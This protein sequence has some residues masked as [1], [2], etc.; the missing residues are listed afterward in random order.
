M[1]ATVAHEHA[2][3]QP[4]DSNDQAPVAEISDPLAM[5]ALAHPLRLRILQLLQ[6]DGP[7][8]ATRLGAALDESSG[9]TS[10]HLRQLAKYG[11]IEELADH[12]SARER[13]WRARA[14]GFR[15]ASIDASNPE[16]ET[17][18]VLLRSRILDQNAEI[19][20]QFLDHE[21]E[22]DPAWRNAALFTNSPAYLTVHEMEELSEEF[23]RLIKRYQRHDPTSRPADA[24][25]VRFMIY[26][27]PE[28]SEQRG[29]GPT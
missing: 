8:T 25:R 6:E 27:L 2:Q 12:G 26:G 15:F 19:L 5:R 9:A 14:R 7:T 11:F 16:F 22:L 17:A 10:F 4:L 18:A 21:P 29:G 20:A 23:L 3:H 13:W 24:R 28:L 1:F